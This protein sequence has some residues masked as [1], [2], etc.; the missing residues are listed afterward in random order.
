MERDILSLHETKA[1]KRSTDLFV[2]EL[3]TSREDIY[4]YSK[5][6]HGEGLNTFASF[7]EAHSLSEAEK[8]IRDSIKNRYETMYG[9]FNKQNRL[10]GA[11]IVV[12]STVDDGEK[13]AEVHY[14][15]AESF[16]R[17]G[18][19]TKGLQ[20]LAELLSN[21]YT[22]FLFSLRKNNISSKLVQEHLGSV[23]QRETRNHLYYKY[24]IA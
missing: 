20:L 1:K 23:L 10:I 9:L 15:I 14:F 18:Y 6:A 17:K 4:A 16:Q 24:C 7:F 5:I 21:T 8:R 13:V 2:R 12:D 19:C 11:F 3:Q 22:Y